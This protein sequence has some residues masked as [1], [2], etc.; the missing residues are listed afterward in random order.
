MVGSIFVPLW[1]INPLLAPILIGGCI[2]G[3]IFHYRVAKVVQ[4]ARLRHATPDRLLQRLGQILTDRN[5]GAE[6]RVFGNGESLIKRWTETRGRRADDVLVAERTKVR[7]LVI[8][9]IAVA[10]RTVATLAIVAWMM[11]EGWAPGSRRRSA[12]G[13]AS[14]SSTLSS[15]W[16]ASPARSQPTLAISSHSNERPMR[17]SRL[18]PGVAPEYPPCHQQTG[19]LT[20]LTARRPQW[21]SARQE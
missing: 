14:A 17:S 1:L 10:A 7:A 15:R 2:P 12:L 16:H 18:M 9:E 4:E 19:R 5:A 20:F 8:S 11:I 21:G 13:G 3:L 6:L